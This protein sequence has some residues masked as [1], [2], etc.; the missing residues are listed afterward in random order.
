[1]SH[2]YEQHVEFLVEC[3]QVHHASYHGNYEMSNICSFEA[4]GLI[5]ETLKLDIE[6]EISSTP[7]L[8]IINGC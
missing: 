2:A 1:M 6:W 8:K 3:V 7:W 5:L 4:I